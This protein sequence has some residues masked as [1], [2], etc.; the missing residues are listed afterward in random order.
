MQTNESDYKTK[1][2]LK[3]ELKQVKCTFKKKKE[4]K[5]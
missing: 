2:S 4:A 3:A 5:L 1:R